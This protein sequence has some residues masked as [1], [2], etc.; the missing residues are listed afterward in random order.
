MRPESAL[1]TAYSQ[2]S[3]YIRRIIAL[4][5]LETSNNT[6]SSS[7]SNSPSAS[8]SSLRPASSNSSSSET[9]SYTV[10]NLGFARSRSGS[11]YRGTIRRADPANA[12]GNRRGNR[13][14]EDENGCV[15]ANKDCSSLE[16][17]GF[18]RFECIDCDGLLAIERSSNIRDRIND[19]YSAKNL[20]QNDSSV[21]CSLKKRNVHLSLQLLPSSSVPPNAVFTVQE[22]VVKAPL[23]GFT[24]PIKDGL[25]FISHEPIPV[26]ATSHFDH[27]D[28]NKYLAYL[29]KSESASI[30]IAP[31]EPAA[32]FKLDY[33]LGKAIVKLE[34]PRSG[35]YILVKM[36]RPVRGDNIDCEFVGFRGFIGGKSFSCGSIC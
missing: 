33:K 3:S 10:S 7:S 17:E 2:Q 5:D 20:L 18:L 14:I 25:V 15:T 19:A 32:Y 30:P 31:I 24:A 9:N 8:S 27:F 6:N 36:L 22:I 4:R 21:Y 28:Q 12:V 11:S 13:P 35:R 34:V 16:K 29:A 23:T 26:E 1:P